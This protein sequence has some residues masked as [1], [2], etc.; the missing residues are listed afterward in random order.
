MSLKTLIINAYGSEAHVSMRDYT[1]HIIKKTKAKTQL[2]FMN[3][4][5]A[6]SGDAVFKSK[7]LHL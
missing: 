2:T 3:R 4:C 7:N 6:C 1:S 5:R